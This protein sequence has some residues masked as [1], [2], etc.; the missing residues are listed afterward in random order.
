MEKRPQW[1]KLENVNNKISKPVLDYNLK[2]K[3]N[4]YDL[5]LLNK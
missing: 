1:P 4:I 2:H 3:I 5:M